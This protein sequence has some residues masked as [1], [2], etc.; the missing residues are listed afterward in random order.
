MYIVKTI[1]YY[2]GYYE[3]YIQYEDC[4]YYESYYEDY[5]QYEDCIYYEGCIYYKNYY[6]LWRLYKIYN[7]DDVAITNARNIIYG[8]YIYIIWI[9]FVFNTRITTSVDIFIIMKIK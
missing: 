9:I 2:E 7:I 8:D 5:I 4:I 1:I 3:D 6:I